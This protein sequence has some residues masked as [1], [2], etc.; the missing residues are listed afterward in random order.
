[1][2]GTLQISL[3]MFRKVF[4]FRSAFTEFSFGG[5]RTK[6]WPS[7]VKQEV[8]ETS[9]LPPPLEAEG[10]MPQFCTIKLVSMPYCFYFF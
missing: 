2:E 8:I 7:C 6:N 9:L 1:M 3:L 10:N 5:N 4:L